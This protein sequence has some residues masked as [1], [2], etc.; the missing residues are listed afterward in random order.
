MAEN[1]RKWGG[2]ST[3]ARKAPN[4]GGGAGKMSFAQKMMAKMGYKEG[5][6]LGREGEGIVNPI[7]VKLRPQGAGVGAVKERTEQY[8]E[9]QRRQ[10][11][12]RGEEM[13]EDSSEEERKA[14]RERRKKGAGAKGGVSG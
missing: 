1:K 6:G 3:G 9:E 13:E 10:A 8:K 2:D 14:R 11:E 7:E 5:Q 12:K 4:L